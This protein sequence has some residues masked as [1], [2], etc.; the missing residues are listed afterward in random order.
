M[1]GFFGFSRKIINFFSEEL[2]ISRKIIRF[3]FEEWGFLRKMINLEGFGECPFDGV[4]GE[5]AGF[6]W[7]L[8]EP[9]F[10]PVLADGL[11]AQEMFGAV[12]G[13]DG[14]G[15]GFG[16]LGE[17]VGGEG[18]LV[19]SDEEPIGGGLGHEVAWGGG[20]GLFDGGR[21][22]ELVEGEFGEE[23]EGVGDGEREG[24]G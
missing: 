13:G 12:E 9:F 4:F 14:D 10:G 8:P 22:G 15:V 7:E 2:E 16:G 23:G 3:G 6:V 20:L 18:A 24:W 11:D 17:G 1:V 5:W 19:E 21:R